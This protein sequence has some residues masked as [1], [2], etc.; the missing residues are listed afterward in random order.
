VK[1]GQKVAKGCG[2]RMNSKYD[3]KAAVMRSENYGC[4][5]KIS[6]RT[7]AIDM[8]IRIEKAPQGHPP[9]QRVKGNK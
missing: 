9:K 3:K 6:T 8:Q 1:R 4:L 2:E 7:I 5:N